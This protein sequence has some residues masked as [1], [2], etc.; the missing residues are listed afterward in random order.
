[1]IG[2]LDQLIDMDRLNFKVRYELSLELRYLEEA[3]LC[4]SVD[5]K[6]NFA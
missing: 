4:C 5:D 1:M 2:I 3:F 6:V